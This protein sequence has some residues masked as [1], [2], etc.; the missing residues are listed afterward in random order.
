[1]DTQK[2][3]ANEWQS[4]YIATLIHDLKTPIS[5]QITALELLLNGSLGKLN[6]T[7]NDILLQVKESCEYAQNLIHSILDTYLYENGKVCLDKEKFS[8]TSL[9][10]NAIKETEPLASDK[11]QKIIVNNELNGSEII[12]DKF[13]IKRA[14]INLISNAI[15]YGFDTSTIEIETKNE[16]D[17]FIFNVKNISKCMNKGDLKNLFNKFQTTKNSK[18]SASCGLGLYLVKQ[19]I[20]AHKGKVFA[21]GDNFG[22]YTFGFSIPK[23]I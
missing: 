17:S 23:S 13:Q 10:N 22:H 9:I 7:Q 6:P 1:M 11:S 19:I 8:W 2:T 4:T 16:K 12:A 5:A 3:Q 21:K 18:N 15:K 20:D 14:M